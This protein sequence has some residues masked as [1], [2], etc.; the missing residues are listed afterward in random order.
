MSKYQYSNNTI[1]YQKARF[2]RKSDTN[3]AAYCIEPFKFFNEYSTY[4]STLNPY[5]LSEEQKT[6]IERIAHFGYGY[7]HHTDE[8]WYAITQMMIWETADPYSG[9]FYFTDS[10]NGNIIYPFQDEINEINNLVN[11]YD[12]LP[13]INNKSFDIVEDQVLIENGGQ[14]MNYYSCYD[15]RISINYNNI[16]L[17]NLKEGEYTFTLY[18]NDNNNNT[19]VIFYQ[20]YDS[21]N[22]I[23]TGDLENKTASFKVNV[24]KTTINVNKVD[25]DTEESIPQGEAELDG[26]VIKVLDIM[27]NIVREI[28]IKDGTGSTENLYFGTYYLKETKAGKGYNVNED[29][30]EI[31]IT[32]DNPNPTINFPNKVIEKNITIKKE[33]GENEIFYPEKN[34][35]FEIYDKDNNLVKT[36]STNE[37]GEIKTVLPYGSYKVIQKNSTEGYQKVEPFNIIVNE[38]DEEIIELKD[39]KIPVPNTSSKKIS[40]LFIISLLLLL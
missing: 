11:S 22:L 21:Q 3:E 28:N 23:K 24:Y 31:T 9:N 20:S 39:Y 27:K 15:D 12:I 7:K 16:V 36:V 2:F 13:D 33:F 5:N 10:L 38:N 8:K 29:L 17:K 32:V 30:I 25:K 14:I 1:Y 26:A 34:I 37:S 35:D 6:R 40:I 18:R 4:E 19:P